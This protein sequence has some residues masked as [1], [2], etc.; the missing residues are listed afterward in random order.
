MGWFEEQVKKRKTLDA[1]TFED[2]FSSLAGIKVDNPHNLSMEQLRENYAISQILSSFHHPMIDIPVTIKKFHEK[3]SYALGQYGVDYRK[4]ELNDS[5]VND[6]R[7]ILL[8]F[9][10]LSN[11]PVVLYP[12]GSKEYYYINYK[13]GKK[14]RIR[15]DLVNKLELEAYS[16]YRPLPNKKISILEY[17]KYIFKSVRPLDIILLLIFS[18]VVAG[19]GLLLPYLTQLF[20]GKVVQDKDLGQFFLVAFYVVGTAAGL[21][22]IKAFQSYV[23]Q[24]IFLRMEKGVQAAAMTKLLHLPPS[25]FKKYN[26]GELTARFTS[27]TSLAQLLVNGV[28]TSVISVV[29]AFAYLFQMGSFA[30]SLILPVVFILL[31]NATFTVFMALYQKKVTATQLQASSKES[32]VT[33]EMIN[34]IQKIRLSG[35]EKRVFAKWAGVYAKSAKLSY[36]PPI[37]I[38]ISPA[39]TLLITLL[40]NIAIYAVAS[41]NN[42]DVASYMAFTTSYGVLSGAFAALTSVVSLLANVS[43][44]YEMARPILEEEVETSKG[45]RS[46][47]RSR[48]ISASSTFASVITRTPHWWSMIFP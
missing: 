44:V 40:G 38:R 41:N 39:I 1:K 26:T 19:V 24:R 21:L 46:S 37:L 33:Y 5:Y 4:V 31:V 47:N 8:V 2:S 11:I 12:V 42:I 17:F 10:F 6:G 9:T 35:S 30:P 23:N 14:V 45:R 7:S 3:L 43:P 48:A 32:G 15:A 29:T 28:F 20:T 34:G 16:F 36:N 18:A 22:I 13:T 25:F 27:V